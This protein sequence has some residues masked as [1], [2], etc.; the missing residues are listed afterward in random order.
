MSVVHRVTG[1]D[2]LS[3]RLE[4]ERD[5]PTALVIEAR[6]VAEAPLDVR[7]APGAFPLGEAAVARLS[8][9]LGFPM[10]VERYDWFL[11]PFEG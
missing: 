6:R 7:D 9:M 4:L 3:E 5:V 2:K 1:Y 10:S 8:G 11:E